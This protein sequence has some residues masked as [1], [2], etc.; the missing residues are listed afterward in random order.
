M[1]GFFI[2]V[3]SDLIVGSLGF[4]EDLD[5]FDQWAGSPARW[6]FGEYDTSAQ[7]RQVVVLEMWLDSIGL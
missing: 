5:P 7:G 1:R 6:R 4:D 2:A 3:V